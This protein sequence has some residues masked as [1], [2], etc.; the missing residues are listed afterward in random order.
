MINLLSH[1]L[2]PSVPRHPHPSSLVS[3]LPKNPAQQQQ[4]SFVCLPPL[5]FSCPLI[6]PR[7]M[8][9]GGDEGMPR[10]ER[11]RSGG[12][13]K[14]KICRTTGREVPLG[15]KRV[16]VLESF[17]NSFFLCSL[18]VLYFFVYSALHERSFSCVC[19]KEGGGFGGTTPLLTLP[20]PVDWDMHKVICSRLF[21][22][23]TKKLILKH[24][25]KDWGR[26]K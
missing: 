8:L 20:T 25:S 17:L 4:C 9:V 12:E 7:T 11:L 21:L 10:Q 16:G 2:S 3:T 13:G 15:K 23:W 14:R 1:T 6:L 26:K 19:G 18:S 5:L 22:V 24:Q